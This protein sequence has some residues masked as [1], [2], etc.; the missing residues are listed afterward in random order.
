M[1]K[2]AEQVTLLTHYTYATLMRKL[3]CHILKI[4]PVD[5]YILD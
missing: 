1:F 3:K 2:K 5:I 4:V